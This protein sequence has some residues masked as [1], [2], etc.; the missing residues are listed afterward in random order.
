MQGLGSDGTL[1]LGNK[2]VQCANKIILHKKNHQ[3]N[4]IIPLSLLKV[5]IHPCMA[6][7]YT[8]DSL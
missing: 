8:A 2:I 5:I 6:A 7:I 4:V 1:Q 3:Q